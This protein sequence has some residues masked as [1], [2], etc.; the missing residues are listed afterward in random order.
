MRKTWPAA[1]SGTVH[2]PKS[3]ADNAGIMDEIRVLR[4][5]RVQQTV[6]QNGK[7]TKSKPQPLKG[8][9]V[10]FNTHILAG[11]LLDIQAGGSGI[12]GQSADGKPDP[13]TFGKFALFTG[14]AYYKEIQ[15]NGRTETHLVGTRGTGKDLTHS[16]DFEQGKGWAGALKKLI[17]KE[18]EWE[19]NANLAEL[20]VTSGQDPATRNVVFAYAFVYFLQSTPERLTAFNKLCQKVDVAKQVPELDEIAKLYGYADEAALKKAWIEWM[21]SGDFK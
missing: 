4:A 12:V 18:K 11:D 16:G 19:P 5:Y 9:W 13:R 1:S 20:W 14:H 3:E 7:V 6:D 15:L 10:P 2:L 8:V 21:S 17:R